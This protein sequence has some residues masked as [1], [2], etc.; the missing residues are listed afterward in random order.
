MSFAPITWVRSLNNK[1]YLPSLVALIAIVWAG[2]YAEIQNN[3][4]SEQ[5]LRA[6]VQYEAGLVRA[7]LEGN[8][9][10]DIQ[11][12]RGMKA[13]ISTEPNISQD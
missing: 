9:A 8:L 10:A 11:L 6:D 4:I 5:Q 13:V 12:L 1:T 3:V 2:I 7:R